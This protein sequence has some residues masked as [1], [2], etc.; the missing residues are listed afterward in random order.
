MSHK[1]IPQTYMFNVNKKN[2]VKKQKQNESN[3][4]NVNSKDSDLKVQS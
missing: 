4:L 3:V 2:S 1:A